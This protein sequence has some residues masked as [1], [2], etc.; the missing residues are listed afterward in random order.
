[1]FSVKSIRL[2]RDEEEVDE[3]DDPIFVCGLGVCKSTSYHTFGIGCV[4]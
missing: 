4:L 3:L 2:H 1:M